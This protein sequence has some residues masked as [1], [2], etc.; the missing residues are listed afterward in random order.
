MIPCR[1]MKRLLLLEQKATL[2]VHDTVN[3]LDVRLLIE[4]EKPVK[5]KMCGCRN[6][7]VVD[8]TCDAH[9]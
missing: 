7:D 9:S 4:I 5:E 1:L 8:I 6:T 3:V 2:D